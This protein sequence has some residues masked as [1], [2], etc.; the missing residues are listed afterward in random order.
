MLSLST[1]FTYVSSFG[2]A[3]LHVSFIILIVLKWVSRICISFYHF[4]NLHNSSCFEKIMKI[5]N[6]N[7]KQSNG[8]LHAPPAAPVARWT[9]LIKT[10][11]TRRSRGVSLSTT[12]QWRY[13]LQRYRQ[14]FIMCKFHV[15]HKT[16][17]MYI[18]LNFVVAFTLRSRGITRL[19]YF[20]GLMPQL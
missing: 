7:F 8:L 16:E 1:A 13:S 9:R 15:I 14:A 19:I 20:S 4:Q 12:T 10:Q 6:N 17:Y 11:P 18:F 5:R 3:Y 2:E